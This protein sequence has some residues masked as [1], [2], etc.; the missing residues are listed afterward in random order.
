LHLA[1]FQDQSHQ[2]LD[3][4]SLTVIK[5]TTTTLAR[6]SQLFRPA[7]QHL[8]GVHR[9]TVSPIKSR[10]ADPQRDIFRVGGNCFLQNMNAIDLLNLLFARTITFF[11]VGSVDGLVH[12]L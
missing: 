4:L 10:K 1:G 11:L 6:C 2:P 9:A 3:H 12:A 5:I 7:D 8:N